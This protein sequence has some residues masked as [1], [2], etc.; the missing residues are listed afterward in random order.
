MLVSLSEANQIR[1]YKQ[2]ESLFHSQ[3]IS[4]FS[5]PA[6]KIFFIL[7][8]LMDRCTRKIL[9]TLIIYFYPI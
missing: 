8:I 1:Y 5:L 2:L 6:F 3:V 7:F 4:R 9:I